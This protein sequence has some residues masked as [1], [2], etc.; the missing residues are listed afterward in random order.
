[1]DGYSGTQF[2]GGG[3]ITNSQEAGAAPASTPQQ[4]KKN[5]NN[6]TLRAVTVKQLV[7][8]LANTPDDQFRVDGV[9]LDNVTL[10]GRL[11][12]MVEQA[13]NL[14]LMLDDG[15]GQVELKY[16]I[17]NDEAE[18]LQQRKAEC[19]VGV[20]VR[21]HGHMRAWD[22]EKSIIAFSIR[23]VTDYN[24]VTYH[25]LQV[26]F[27]HLHITKGNV[28]P[29]VDGVKAEATTPVQAANTGFNAAP[30]GGEGLSPIQKAVATVL[31]DGAAMSD[32]ISLQEITNRLGPR[33][34]QG[35]IADTARWLCEEGHAYQIDDSHFK[36]TDC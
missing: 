10:V 22:G 4:A 5:N 31:K 19:R 6:Q 8:G 16:W 26:I 15:T 27:Q 3:F 36:S 7:D 20:Y 25:A 34:D 2:A 29:P 33:Y 12:S 35:A 9:D 24:E 21:V 13:T 18:L 23:P 30:D 1:M 11:V 32:G 14:T 28:F 17:D